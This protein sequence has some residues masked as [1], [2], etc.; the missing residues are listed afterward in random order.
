MH[1]D[2]LDLSYHTALITIM[3]ITK[4]FQC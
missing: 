3:I 1:S 4:K 2:A